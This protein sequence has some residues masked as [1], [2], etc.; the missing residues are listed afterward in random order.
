[1]QHPEPERPMDSIYRKSAHNHLPGEAILLKERDFI[2]TNLIK[3]L[4]YSVLAFR[5]PPF[6]YNIM[7]CLLA[8]VKGL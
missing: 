2:N 1:M 8:L 3:F 5:R 4:A 6:H 7:L